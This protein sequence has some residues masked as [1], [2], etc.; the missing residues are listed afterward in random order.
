[1]DKR[2][3][4]IVCG[5]RPE[6]IKL[7]PVYHALRAKDE[8]RVVWVHTGQHGEMAADMLRSFGITP[9]EQLCR[10]GTSLEE[11]SVD[12]RAQLDALMARQRWDLCVVQGDTESAFLG[13]LAAF[14]RRIP[15]GHVEAGLRTH[16]LERPFPEEDRR[17]CPR[18]TP[19]LGER[20]PGRN[21]HD[22][23]EHAVRVEVA[24]AEVLAPAL[25]A[26]GARRLPH[27]LAQQAHEI[28]G[29]GDVVAVAAVIREDDVARGLEVRDHAHGVG[30]LAD[31]RMG[32]ADELARG[33]E[34]EQR[35]LQATDAVHALVE[36][37]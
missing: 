22:A 27:H 5:T 36:A 23:S 15:V 13:A 25:A 21:R 26:A 31:A 33:E 17:H 14:Y 1:M 12:C 11:F 2:I 4:G 29:E 3:V 8:L 24:V 9:D 34:V 37:L 30:L 32:G 7:A 35:L 19:R 18:P 10:K 6:I 28:S 20:H 16:N